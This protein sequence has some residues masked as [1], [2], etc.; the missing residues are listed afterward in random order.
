[1]DA[2]KKSVL[3]AAVHYDVPRTTLKDRISGRVVHGTNPG[4]KPYLN[5]AKE[6]ELSHCG[7]NWVR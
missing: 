6:K 7:K 3:R 2:V 5:K 1:M 4:A